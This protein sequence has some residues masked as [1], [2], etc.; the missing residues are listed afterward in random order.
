MG[1]FP[2]PVSGA[3]VPADRRVAEGSCPKPQPEEST[4]NHRDVYGE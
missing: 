3:Q 1:F 4:G 2:H